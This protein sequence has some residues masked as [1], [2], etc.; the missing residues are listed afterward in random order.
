VKGI[1]KSHDTS[2]YG[3]LGVMLI[4]AFQKQPYFLK[5]M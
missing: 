3:P 5:P 2:Y 4:M 1:K